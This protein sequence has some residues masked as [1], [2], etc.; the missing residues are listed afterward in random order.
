[1]ALLCSEHIQASK[2]Q[3]SVYSSSDVH[4]ECVPCSCR[5]AKMGL[6]AGNKKAVMMKR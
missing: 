4:P 2:V 1:M 6:R 5:K 3:S